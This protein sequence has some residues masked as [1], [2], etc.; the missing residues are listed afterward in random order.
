VA[1]TSAGIAL[2]LLGATVAAGL[3]RGLLFGIT[4]LDAGTFV[5]V[6]LLFGIV[7]MAASYLPAHR[8]TRIDPVTALR[9]E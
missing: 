9:S 5:A 1:L 8:A 2:G 3:L 6:P 4:P 7:A